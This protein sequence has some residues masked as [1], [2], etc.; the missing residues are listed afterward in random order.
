MVVGAPTCYSLELSRAK[1][2]KPSNRKTMNVAVDYANHSNNTH[3]RGL[4]CSIEK[5]RVILKAY[6]EE[7]PSCAA[8]AEAAWQG[9]LQNLAE[10]FPSVWRPTGRQ[11]VLLCDYVGTYQEAGEVRDD[12]EGVGEVG[13]W[14]IV[15]PRG[16]VVLRLRDCVARKSRRG[17]R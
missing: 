5:V 4:A 16:G 17:R 13:D 15:D 10:T 14:A 3:G 2:P 12:R 9:L 7:F 6:C 1:H 8:Q 11:G